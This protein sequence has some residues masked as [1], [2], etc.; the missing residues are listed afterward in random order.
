[1]RKV[2]QWMITHEMPLVQLCSPKVDELRIEG[3]DWAAQIIF[4]LRCRMEKFPKWLRAGSHGVSCCLFTL[5]LWPDAPFARA[6][7]ITLDLRALVSP[8]A[9]SSDTL[10]SHHRCPLILWSKVQTHHSSPLPTRPKNAKGATWTQKGP[11]SI[12]VG[13]GKYISGR[14]GNS[15]TSSSS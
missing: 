4:G 10:L 15:P 8:I 9:R 12:R 2:S 6:Q 5:N 13:Y 11:D 3:V 7:S 1:M 14:W